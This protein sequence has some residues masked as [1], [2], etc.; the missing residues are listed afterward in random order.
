MK[1]EKVFI[2]VFNA[3]RCEKKL[4]NMK[5]TEKKYFIRSLYAFSF[6]CDLSR[7]TLER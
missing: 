2:D 7:R 3:K 1:K 4:F 6:F 5:M